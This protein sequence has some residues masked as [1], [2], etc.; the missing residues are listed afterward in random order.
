MY[1]TD[2]YVDV[3][4]YVFARAS[5]GVGRVSVRIHRQ[6]CKGVCV[7]VFCQALSSTPAPGARAGRRAPP[8]RLF[9]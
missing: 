5:V 2:A 7:C 1:H 3:D 9:V 4:A 6:Q 8:L